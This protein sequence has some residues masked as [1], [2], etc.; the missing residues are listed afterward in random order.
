MTSYR[1]VISRQKDLKASMLCVHDEVQRNDTEYRVQS[2]K[3]ESNKR[4]SVLCICST[5]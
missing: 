5:N 4:E 1:I 2:M 3:Y